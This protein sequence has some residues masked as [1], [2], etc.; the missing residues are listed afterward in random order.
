MS[1]DETF[2]EFELFIVDWNNVDELSELMV[3]DGVIYDS[4]TGMAYSDD[5]PSDDR[6]SDDRPSDDK[7]F[8]DKLSV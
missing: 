3:G 2:T 7:L 5:R 4:V 6:P 1:D 8:D